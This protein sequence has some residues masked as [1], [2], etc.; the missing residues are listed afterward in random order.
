MALSPA[1][2]STADATSI[3]LNFN[4]NSTSLAN[5]DTVKYHERVIHKVQTTQA[6]LR[7]FV[8]MHPMTNVVDVFTLTSSRDPV[9]KNDVIRTIDARKQTF[10]TVTI[11]CN[12]YDDDCWLPKITV[13]MGRINF[14]NAVTMAMEFG[15]ERLVSK[16]AV[17]AMLA[18]VRAYD[19][20]TT[21]KTGELSSSTSSLGNDRIG[22]AYKT[23]GANKVLSEPTLK[24]LEAIHR[25]KFGSKNV[26][27]SVK[28]CALCTPNML[29]YLRALTEYKNRD[30]IWT[31]EKPDFNKKVFDFYGF[32]WIKCPPQVAPGAYYASK[33]LT[34]GAADSSD[35]S[36]VT[37]TSASNFDLSAT[38][39]EAIP[40]WFPRN[41]A[42]GVYASQKMFEITKVPYYRNSAVMMRTEWY[43]GSRVQN[44]LQYV[45][46]I[47]TPVV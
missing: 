5:I 3:T 40:I 13:D 37:D 19:N 41:V 1:R 31:T 42:V 21:W 45:L 23:V 38:N 9:A 44:V 28:F 11:R 29:S 22:G 17:V 7:P 25:I 30:F 27:P 24:T 43:G 16:M 26:D 4:L 35:L 18:D 6:I 20:T 8:T 32:K 47:P 46:L 10:E 34:I 12:P 33:F 15:Y 39:H 2:D 36:D 14:P